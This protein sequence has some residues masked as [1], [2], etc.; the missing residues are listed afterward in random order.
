MAFIPGD[1]LAP[2]LSGALASQFTDISGHPNEA[3]ISRLGLLGVVDSKDGKAYPDE[4]AT[5]VDL[6][7]AMNRVLRVAVN[8][9]AQAFDDVPRD[10]TYYDDV[11]KAF[12]AGL[13]VGVG[14]NKFLPNAPVSREQLV[15]MMGRIFGLYNDNTSILSGIYEDNALATYGRGHLAAFAYMGVTLGIEENE[16]YYFYPH[17]PVTR[18]EMFQFINDFLPNIFMGTDAYSSRTVNGNLLI[19]SPSVTIDS[20]TL[21][22]SL[23]LADGI[24]SG[25]AA[26]KNS[27]INGR[28]IIR[29]GGPYSVNLTGTVVTEGVYVY[30]PYC[31]TRIYSS[32]NLTKIGE[33]TAMTDITLEGAGFSTL[34]I[35]QNAVGSFVTLRDVILDSLNVERPFTRVRLDGVEVDNTRFSGTAEGSFMRIERDAR[36]NYMEI[37]ADDITIAGDGSIDYLV[38]NADGASVTIRPRFVSIAP[39][40]TAI[41]DGEVIKGSEIDDRAN[42]N[43]VTRDSEAMQVRRDTVNTGGSALTLTTAANAQSNS[44][45]IAHDGS[46]VQI[47]QQNRLGYFIG[48]LI[49]APPKAQNPAVKIGYDFEGANDYVYSIPNVIQDGVTGILVYIPVKAGSNL[50][51]SIDTTLYI[52]WGNGLYETLIF[53][54][55]NFKLTQPTAAQILRM[56]NQ[57]ANAVYPSY[58]RIATFT[59]SEAL[60][61]LLLADNP[62]GLDIRSF[63]SYTDE[64]RN[65]FIADMYASRTSFTSKPAI[66]AYL[67]DK[68]TEIGGLFA[69]N[70]AMTAKAMQE[71]IENDNLAGQLGIDTLAGS[72]YGRLSDYG[73][74][75]V[76]NA[77]ITARSAVADGKFPNEEAFAKAFNTAVSERRK[78]EVNV[79]QIINN[80]K[81]VPDMQK[82]LETKVNA[83]VIGIITAA[84]P[85][86]AMAKPEKETVMTKI[87][88]E[89]QFETLDDVRKLFE[90]LVGTPGKPIVIDPEDNPNITKVEANPNTMTVV[91]GRSEV[92]L[93]TIVTSTGSFLADK[94]HVTFLVDKSNIA[95][96]DDDGMVRGIAKGTAKVTVTSKKDPKKKATVSIKVEELVAITSMKIRPDNATVNVGSQVQLSIVDKQ[97]KTANEKIFWASDDE[98]IATVSNGIVTGVKAGITS[99]KAYTEGMGAV[100]TCVINVSSTE[101]SIVIDRRV[102]STIGS[103]GHVQLSATVSP[104]TISNPRVRWETSNSAVATVNGNGLVTGA[105]EGASGTVT[106]S[107]F[108]VAFPNLPPDTIE[109]T[110]DPSL[111]SLTL[112]PRDVTLYKDTTAKLNANVRGPAPINGKIQWSSSNPAIVSVDDN[113]NIRWRGEGT[114]TITASYNGDYRFSDTCDVTALKDALKVTVT[115]DPV[116]PK[117]STLTINVGD[118][119]N[120]MVAFA[121]APNS[122][123]VE[124]IASETDLIAKNYEI[125][126]T[127]S[128]S[129]NAKITGLKAGNY[130]VQV[131]PMATG[132]IAAEIRFTVVDKPLTSISLDH[133]LKQLYQQ[134][135]ETFTVRY[136]PPDATVQTVRW[137]VDKS[138]IYVLDAANGVM[139][140]TTPTIRTVVIPDPETP[141]ATMTSIVDDGPVT[142][143]VEVTTTSGSMTAKWSVHVLEGTGMGQVDSIK[144]R[145]RSWVFPV[146]S[147]GTNKPQFS[148]EYFNASGTSIT[149]TNP[150]VSWRSDKPD[151]ADIDSGGFLTCKQVGTANIVAESVDGNRIDSMYIVVAPIAVTDIHLPKGSSSDKL[152]DDGTNDWKRMKPGESATIDA[153][154]DASATYKTLHWISSDPTVVEVDRSTGKMTALKEGEA[155]ITVRTAP[156]T[157]FG[158]GE[159]GK[160]VVYSAGSYVLDT[161]VHSVNRLKNFTADGAEDAS[162]YFWEDGLAMPLAIDGT[163]TKTFQ[164]WVVSDTVTEANFRQSSSELNDSLSALHTGIPARI[165]VQLD[166]RATFSKLILTIE[167]SAFED[168]ISGGLKRTIE[169]D[170][171]NPPSNAT[172]YSSGL[173]VFNYTPDSGF[174]GKN[175]KLT[176]EAVG[177]LIAPGNFTVGDAEKIRPISHIVLTPVP[178]RPPIDIT[179]ASGTSLVDPPLH[180]GNSSY[181]LRAEKVN[182]YTGSHS[183][184][185]GSSNPTVAAIN[186]VNGSLEA[187]TPGVTTITA[188]IADFQKTMEVNVILGPSPSS[189]Q[190]FTPFDDTPDKSFIPFSIPDYIFEPDVQIPENFFS[191]FSM[192]QEIIEPT[193]QPPKTLEFIIP[194]D[195]E[196][197][198]PSYLRIRSSAKVL[199]GTTTKLYPTLRPSNANQLVWETEDENIADIVFIDENGNAVISGNSPG[200]TTITLRS[201][202]GKYSSKCKVTVLST[203]PRPTTDLKISRKNLT[204]TLGNSTTLDTTVSPKNASMAGVSWYSSNPNVATVDIYGKVT[205][206]SGGVCTITAVTDDGSVATCNVLVRVRVKSI[207][208][209]VRSLTLRVGEEN[210]YQLTAKVFPENATK[211][212]VTWK[213]SNES[214]AYVDSNGVVTPYRKGTAK[215]TASCDGRNITCTV[216]VIN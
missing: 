111:Y 113:G 112:D 168:D 75:N 44:V 128:D 138:N 20:M 58:N 123:V 15:T 163:V 92:I 145:R 71:I 106:I 26:I 27:K 132:L 12:A 77:L 2:N 18:A 213:S 87:F 43:N 82:V 99:V 78:Q 191:P 142:I 131:K 184:T 98:S 121:P 199:S 61:R 179:I 125:S 16:T 160:T 135:R 140:G 202:D 156:T 193:V 130:A 28:L 24:E 50:T 35:P 214:V 175:I 206:V 5:R 157:A 144:I 117:N 40:M 70:T 181:T 183:V 31:E 153:T 115:T 137:S 51:G 62:L 147:A 124:Y 148:V 81:S 211:T 4:P 79:L 143:S 171:S 85:Y 86:K 186:P 120:I 13:I 11:Q 212:E 203:N 149:P 25:N 190:L 165:G 97:P 33:I 198:K 37:N 122:S 107:A 129:P 104:S 110:V 182:G 205:A 22:G 91:I 188:S 47:T 159:N 108:A 54:G 95:T 100:A 154:V 133:N 151:V 49:P 204:M 48:F 166:P 119:F 17:R 94:E 89:L 210:S 197:E 173:V 9:N 172:Y 169:Y 60:K 80:T 196:P 30:N 38:I 8:R 1:F 118:S 63:E 39:G 19:R 88:A 46:P 59:G 185:W 189:S 127:T 90:Q 180:A 208:I 34:H 64:E 134:Q 72:D 150:G 200:T 105:G 101:P 161:N 93:A 57:F 7:S 164:V 74:L 114:A 216:T 192:A 84:N 66:Q 32:N 53:K 170:P 42:A 141:G 162:G 21:N 56:V 69:V 55:D 167:G 102:E 136:T 201:V 96:V 116:P 3:A 174:D 187:L 177:L 65:S 195:T 14:D 6:I 73:K 126:K 52:T 152:Q 29:G 158:E 155:T 207:S 139:Q 76:A 23:I 68:I 36:V 83:D 146:Y 215:I 109:I 10:S 67:N 178:V 41:V 176:F 194:S 209:S 103:F 45:N